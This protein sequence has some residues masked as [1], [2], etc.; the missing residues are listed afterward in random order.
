[1]EFQDTLKVFDFDGKCVR[2]VEIDGQPWWLAKDV[3]DVLDIKNVS[4]AIMQLEDDERSMFYIGR[5]GNANIINYSSRA[6]SHNI[7]LMGMATGY[8]I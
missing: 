7:F 2:V 4:Q 6:N 5:Q 3:C 8:F 1:M